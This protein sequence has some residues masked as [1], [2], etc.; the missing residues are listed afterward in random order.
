[1][2]CLLLS[3]DIAVSSLLIDVLKYLSSI[4][5]SRIFFIDNICF[6]CGIVILLSRRPKTRRAWVRLALD[7]VS[8]LIFW[9]VCWALFRLA[10]NSS[11]VGVVANLFTLMFYA[12]LNH[13]YTGTVR[14]ICA[15]VYMSCYILLI[16]MNYGAGRIMEQ[17]GVAVAE[18]QSGG[19]LVYIMMIGVI[20]FLRRWHISDVE[21][22]P[23]GYMVLM[24]TISV[25]SVLLQLYSFND[26][27]EEMFENLHSMMLIVNS[28]FLLVQLMAYYFYYTIGRQISDRE[29]WMALQHK[30]ELEQDVLT[31]ARQTYESLS[32]LRHEIKNHDAY[33]AALLEQRDYEGL[34]AYFAEY[35]F[36]HNEAVRFVRSGN[37]QVDAIVNNRM[38]R[39]GMLGVRIETML[40]LPQQLPIS[41]KDLC[42]LLSNLLDNAVEGCIS[43]GTEVDRKVMF[44]MR[45]DGSYL[46]LRTENP[47]SQEAEV[48]QRHLSLRTTKDSAVLHG[49]GTKI[50]RRIVEKYDGAVTF[51]IKQ[52]Q[53]VVDAMLLLID[54]RT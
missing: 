35:R 49:Y 15:A 2:V 33:M 28:C 50:I 5:T 4:M 9:F 19:L 1:M 16:G 42:S 38:T 26:A 48:Q 46:F 25:L 54:E 21:Q 12:L 34:Q 39:A 6:V 40:A 30:E 10:W 52:E 8:C 27:D 41:E 29:E 20:V 23:S 7:A 32:E 13:Q 51:Q 31:T 37:E 43:C 47:I 53:F 44:H 14:T 22:L 36:E 18:A 3:Q 45:K 17:W 24:M 11:W